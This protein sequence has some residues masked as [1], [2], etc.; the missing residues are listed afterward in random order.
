MIP[1]IAGGIVEAVGKIA[2]DL[3]TSDKERLQAEIDMRKLDLEEQRIA[4]ATDLAQI[5]VNSDEAK[6]SNWFV[7]G[8]RPFVLWVCGIALAY[9][10]LIE[11][12]ARFAAKVAFGYAG[13][14]PVIDTEL[15]L[16]LLIGLLGLGGMRSYE[17]VR[18]V[19]R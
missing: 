5:A 11:P 17:K 6:S 14:F 19:A 15:T 16:Q 12:V 9:A 4:Q 2:D 18:G 7:A 10:S 13:E 1:L 3:F 8:G